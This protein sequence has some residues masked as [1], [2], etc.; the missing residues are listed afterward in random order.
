MGGRM[1]KTAIFCQNLL[2]HIPKEFSRPNIANK[3]TKRHPLILTNAMTT[4][5]AAQLSTNNPIN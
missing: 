4:A 1:A 2:S 3:V 5:V